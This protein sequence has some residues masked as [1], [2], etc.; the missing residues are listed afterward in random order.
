MEE[1]IRE[2]QEF[3]SVS[4]KQELLDFVASYPLR[5]S[6]RVDLTVFSRFNPDLADAILEKPDHYSKIAEEALKQTADSFGILPEGFKP[7][8]RFHNVPTTEILVKDLGAQHLNRLVQ[9]QGV[10]NLMT[11]IR[12]KMQIALWECAYCERTTK[13]YPDKGGLKAPVVCGHCGKKDFTLLEANSEFTNTQYGQLQDLLERVQ[14]SQAPSQV[15]LWFEDDLTNIVL[16]GE[17]I[18]VT[19]ILRLMPR[20]E[21][22][23]AK[24]SVYGKA[25]DVLFVKR[26]EKEF[27]EIAISKEEE[28]KILEL[29]DNPRLKELIIESVAPSIYGHSEVKQAITLQLFGGT[30]DKIL[31]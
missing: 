28:K 12:P 27:E 23:R 10:V 9:V 20:L 30:P 16:P 29:R 4:L 22:G 17:T 24:S 3:F 7:H 31:P 1:E 26:E 25:F 18:I 6:L 21:K 15:D 2:F 13:N 19:G 8:V 11:D 5:R 14:G